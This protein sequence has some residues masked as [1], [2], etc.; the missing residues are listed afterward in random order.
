MRTQKGDKRSKKDTSSYEE[1]MPTD[2]E[3]PDLHHSSTTDG[4]GAI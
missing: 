4:G 3:N 1:E 2:I